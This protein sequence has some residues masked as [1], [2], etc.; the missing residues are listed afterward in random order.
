MNN[1]LPPVSRAHLELPP[2]PASV[3]RARRFVADM[4][5]L[6][7]C[8]DA[9]RLA[10]LLTSEVVTNAVRYAHQ[11]VRVDITADNNTIVVAT[12]DDDPRPPRPAAAPLEASGGRGLVLVDAL[13]SRW[14]T[15]PDPPGKT[16]WFEL[17]L[18]SSASPPQAGTGVARR[19]SPPPLRPNP[20]PVRQ[21]GAAPPG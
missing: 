4:L 17:H 14:G 9:A 16:V 3:A 18:P 19:S 1:A 8:D 21:P 10:V 12:T 11:T 20:R 6:W 15:D 5:A 2:E 7:E 13:A